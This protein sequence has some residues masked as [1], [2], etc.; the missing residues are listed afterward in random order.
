MCSSTD[1]G[2]I[3]SLVSCMTS[4]ST[5]RETNG[6]DPLF[7]G[8][9]SS[10]SNTFDDKIPESSKVALLRTEKTTKHMSIMPGKLDKDNT[11][12][13]HT[14]VLGTLLYKQNKNPKDDQESRKQPMW[15]LIH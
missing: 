4:L 10:S 15:E 2:A 3:V 7:R 5:G 13:R 11:T 14:K 8:K 12:H 9:S 6:D 1:A